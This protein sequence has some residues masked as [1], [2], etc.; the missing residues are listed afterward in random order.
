MTEV[1]ETRQLPGCSFNTAVLGTE[2][3]MSKGQAYCWFSTLP[4]SVPGP[5]LAWLNAELEAALLSVDWHW[6][7][8]LAK[9]AKACRQTQFPGSM[10]VFLLK[11]TV[12]A[13]VQ[14]CSFTGAMKHINPQW[15]QASLA[16]GHVAAPDE[17][18]LL[19]PEIWLAPAFSYFC[20]FESNSLCCLARDGQLH[21]MVF[22]NNAAR[23]CLSD[24]CNTLKQKTQCMG[25]KCPNKAEVRWGLGKE[26]GRR[27]ASPVPPPM[28]YG[29]CDCYM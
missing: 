9:D 1:K 8:G 17:D 13:E 6:P 21:V 24:P 12:L 4:C 7:S 14:V 10:C 5:E 16:N 23:L 29:T 28:I 18:S 2:H 25:Y 3:E 22:E 26:G 20:E 15:G 11:Q 19:S 27:K